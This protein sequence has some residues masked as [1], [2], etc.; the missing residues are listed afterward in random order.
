MLSPRIPLFHHAVVLFLLS[1]SW[2]ASQCV[3]V[4]AADQIS[5]H[6][7]KQTSTASSPLDDA[8]EEKVTWVLENFK[9]PGV[10]VSVVKGNETFAKGYGLSDISELIPVTEHTHFVAGSTTKAFLS[11]AVSLLVDDNTSYPHIQWDT[12]I[13]RII[14]DDFILSD[15]W[16][17]THVTIEDALSHR[18]GLPRHDLS[19]MFGNPNTTT[20]RDVVRKMRHLPLTEPIRTKFQY[21]NLMYA[22][23]AHLVEVVTGGK[24]LGDFLKERIWDPL[25][26]K[27]T[28]L[29]IEDGRAAGV[30][31][32][33]G[34]RYKY[35][36][37]KA[38]HDDQTGTGPGGGDGEDG[39]YEDVG[40]DHWDY[41]RG[42]GMTLSSATDYAKW[43]RAMI[44]RRPNAPLSPEGF[45]A[46]TSARS[47]AIPAIVPPETAPVT[48]GLGWK[49]H[50]YRGELF[51]EHQ[52]AQP[53]FATLVA[54]LPN[55]E[56]GVAVFCN[57][58][59]GGGGAT[60]VLVYHLIDEFLGI[61]V[62]ERVDWVKRAEIEISALSQISPD[63]LHNLY[64][65]RPDP[66]LP[67]SLPISAYEGIYVH[68]AYPTLNISAHCAK[69]SIFPEFPKPDFTNDKGAS[70][71]QPPSLCA[72][73]CG[74]ILA[75][76]IEFRH[77]SGEFWLVARDFWG[78]HK[79]TRAEFRVAPHGTV[80]ELGVEFEP[81]M[82]GEKIWFRRK[83]EDGS[84]NLD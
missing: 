83:L 65:A 73:I 4:A 63:V 51:I 17:T 54:F 72:T 23:M 6:D 80:G 35:K 49:I 84:I 81:T 50:A 37:K 13:H 16:Y 41:G 39:E 45:T 33:R 5:L 40:Y 21:C 69:P 8:F 44:E 57:N 59:V 34:Y 42:A 19:W 55:R 79:A 62:E 71:Q 3:V 60:E 66:P 7:D 24:W 30:D 22:T 12:P 56:F 25:G 1:L 70:L 61:P 29:S 74:S 67:L 10:A 43:I 64:P 9:I 36:Y 31:I 76:T 53:G 47:I 28:Y 82:K 15:P 48:Y 32:S 14:P 2:I 26:M 46:V 52:G 78:E 77:V 38:N 75:H 20:L 27:E 11:A 68:P 58:L 18:S